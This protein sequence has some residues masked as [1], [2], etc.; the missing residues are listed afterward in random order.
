MKPYSILNNII[1]LNIETTSIHAINDK[2]I[3]IGAIKI[4]DKVVT[5]FNILLNSNIE[6]L[7]V[8]LEDL[9]LICYESIFNESFPKINNEYLD[10][11]EL[12][13]ILFPELSEFKLQKLIKK[14]LPKSK[15]E[16]HSGASFLEDT[17][18]LLNYTISRFYYENG[19]TLPMSIIDLEA[20][21]WYKYLTK[22]NIDDVKYFIDNKP[23]IFQKKTSEPYPVFALKDYEKLFEN[24]DIWKRDG[25]NYTFRAQQRDAAGFIREGLEKGK[26]VIME[27]PTGLGKSMSYL[28]PASIFAYLRNEK[29]IIS[30]NTK[31]LQNQLVDKDIPNLLKALNLEKD[32]SYTLIKGK[33]NYLCFDRFEDIEYPKDM[34]TL[35]GYVYL[36]RLIAEKGYGDIEEI[37]Y[38]I[39]ER[40]NLNYLLEKCCCDSEL[41]DVDSCKYKERC[42]YALKVE[43][44]KEAQLIVVNHSL[45]LKW[46]YQSI[47]PLENIM[48]DEAHNLNQEVYDAF[49][50]SLVSNELERFLKEIYDSKEKSGYLYYLS[51]KIKKET[52]PL[53][54]VESEIEKCE[55]QIKSIR[56]AFENYIT[57]NGISKEYNIKE[58]LNKSELRLTAILKYLEYLKEDIANLNIY[59]DK[60][61]NVLRD[62][63]I[64][65]KDKRFKILI[66]KVEVLNSYIILLET[67]ISQSEEGYCFY[68]EVDK[69]LQWWKISSIPLDVSGVFYEKVLNG[70]KSCLFISAT[71]S[72]DNNYNNLKN[73]LGINIAK[74]QNKEIL[75]IPPIKPVFDYKGKS[76]IYAVENI[77]PNAIETF[78]EELKS[79]VLE[80]LYNVEGNIILLFTSR[81]RLNAFKET[82][83]DNLNALGIRVVEGKKDVEKLRSREERYILLG[84]KSF[85]EG[86]DI[87]GDTMTTVVLDKVPNINS[88]EPFYKS[89]IDNQVKSGKNYWHAYGKVNFPIVS[90]DLKQIYGRIIRTEYDYGSLFIMSKFD[91]DNN[92]T[93][94]KLESQL[95]EVPVIR[96]DRTAMFE[97]LNLRIIRW[98][99]MNLY[100]IMKEVKNSLKN[101]ISEKKEYNEVK[102]LK[103]IEAAINEF[104]ASE[105]SK[106]NLKYDINI[107]LEKG[108]HIFIKNIEV[109]LGSSRINIS[110]YFNDII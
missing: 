95:H 107:Y 91:S 36:K 20:W 56:A 110:R 85:F 14:F 63:A 78:S 52:L 98:K 71:L 99:K 22:V 13:I 39:K 74:S 29:V 82:A 75:E 34:K 47:V 81:K 12:F 59:L 16:K 50:N 24:K 76:A 4:K 86:I 1:F 103:E 77:D 35:I 27:A 68:F 31:G 79:F 61:V 46:P 17:I 54:E 30:T 2:I 32:I 93:I 90:I 84:S 38:D 49:E 60:A 73:T 104:M 96:K 53:R 55:F 89:L 92:L 51:K 37:S 19:Y 33:S 105:Y 28:L 26:I 40:F 88:K 62:I 8:F 44:L 43:S 106:R 42:Y 25:R 70:T 65:Q 94:K 109:N 67:V 66:E 11:L 80:L 87:P 100:K 102:S 83:I 64:V 9:P 5:K 10:L 15:S 69:Y 57:S 48:M 72:T 21:N 7:L 18:M 41:C 3:E 23:N 101:F 58:H 108:L 97:D 6:E 45:L